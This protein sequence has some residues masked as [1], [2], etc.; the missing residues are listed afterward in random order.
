MSADRTEETVN[1][2][3]IQNASGKSPITIEAAPAQ[4]AE[5]YVIEV[6][7]NNNVL[8]DTLTTSIQDYCNTIIKGNYDAKEQAVAKALLN[9]GALAN[10]YFGYSAISEAA[11]PNTPYVVEHTS[12][13]LDDVDTDEIKTKARAQ[14][15]TGV[16]L[17]YVPGNDESGKPIYVT[18]VAYVA[19]LDPEF[20][21]YVSQENEV[22]AALT[23]VSITDLDGNKIEGVTAKM[24]K[25]NAGN[26]VRVTG[27]KAGEFG[28]PFILNIG[29]GKLTYNGYAYLYSALTS[30]SVTNESLKNLAKGVYRYAA[31]CE[32]KANA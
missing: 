11:N 13:Y 10:D 14:V 2:D 27:I 29:G 32:A 16:T 23:P 6:Y 15:P 21:F 31:A 4:I 19:L 30:N 17:G 8:I 18:N 20:R 24:I 25:T 12:D 9:Y 28:K 26:C 1:V 5:P 3:D 22:W 7:N